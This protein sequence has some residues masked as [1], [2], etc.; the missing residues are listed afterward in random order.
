MKRLSG[1]FTKLKYIIGCTGEELELRLGY[2]KG[3]F[4][5][6]YSVYALIEIPDENMF[7]LRGYSMV[8]EQHFMEKYGSVSVGGDLKQEVVASFA[9]DGPNSLVKIIPNKAH[10][11]NKDPD[12]QYPVGT[13]IPQWKI[14]R[15]INLNA[16]LLKSMTNYKSKLII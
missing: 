14:K 6:G 10:D 11:E 7:Q 9:L 13:G 12:I 2:E 16:V 5:D 4:A 3:R 15:G 8:P 1:Y